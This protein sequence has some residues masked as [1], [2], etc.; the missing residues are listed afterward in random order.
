M[1]LPQVGLH[2]PLSFI[3]K[4][5]Y[6]KIKGVKIIAI[7]ERVPNNPRNSHFPKKYRDWVLQDRSAK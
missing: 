6:L 7:L 5:L 1:L 2:T 3:L 4:L